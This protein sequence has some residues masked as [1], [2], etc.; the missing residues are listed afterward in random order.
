MGQG[1]CDGVF[2]SAW[3][4][5]EQLSSVAGAVLGRRAWL[6]MENSGTALFGYAL[7]WQWRLQQGG[8]DIKHLAVSDRSAAIIHVSF[9]SYYVQR[10]GDPVILHR[11][12]FVD[13]GTA[14]MANL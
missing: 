13:E 14:T 3:R 5:A 10:A 4:A 6:S 8:S 7:C 12:A 9:I 2:A 1:E 11:T